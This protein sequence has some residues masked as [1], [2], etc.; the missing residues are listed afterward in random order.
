MISSNIIEK[1]IIV[2]YIES[3]KIILVQFMSVLMIK[4]N[5]KER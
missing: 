4:I 2:L 3:V 1:D 5:Q